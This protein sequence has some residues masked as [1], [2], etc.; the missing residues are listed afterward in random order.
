[1]AVRILSIQ[2]RYT[3][4]QCFSREWRLDFCDMTRKRSKEQCRAIKNKHGGTTEAHGDCTQQIDGLVGRHEFQQMVED[5][6]RRELQIGFDQA[7]AGDVAAWNLEE[8]LQEA[9]RR[10]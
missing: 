1:M 4:V 9:R 8:M 7:D 6:L 5:Q 10:Q 3:G 2:R